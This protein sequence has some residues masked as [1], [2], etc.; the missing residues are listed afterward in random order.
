MFMT[1]SATREGNWYEKYYHDKR[2][3]YGD[4]KF[5]VSTPTLPA[6]AGSRA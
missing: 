5:H 1:F 6:P 4:P 2:Q 3:N